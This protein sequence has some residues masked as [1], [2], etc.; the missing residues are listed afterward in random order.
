MVTEFALVFPPAGSPLVRLDFA[1]LSYRQE[2]TPQR[3]AP[4]KVD[5]KG[6][7]IQFLGPLQL[8]ETL[9][10]AADLIG[11]V[12]GITA[13]PAGVTARFSLPIP[14]VRC[15]AFS[16]SNVVFHSAV[17][18]PFG[19]DP[20]AVSIGFASRAN[21]FALSVLV[22]GGGGYVDIRLDANGP[23]IE[24]SLEF[25]AMMSVDF[26][27]ASGEVH[28]LG[29]VRYLQEGSSVE[30][31]G[32]VRIGGSVDVL[33]LVSVSIELVVSLAYDFGRKL[34][35]GRATLVLEIDLTFW[36]DSIEIDSGE[37]VLQGG[38]ET[39]RTI[40]VRDADGRPFGDRILEDDE[41]VFA[42]LDAP[43][44]DE[45]LAAWRDYRSAFAR[46]RGDG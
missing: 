14:A 41:L 15:G 17:E 39:V 22:F 44:T 16:L 45:E 42:G 32:F 12:P 10:K 36:S 26:V 11:S 38:D 19:G 34:L 27:V 5:V 23:R 33:G 8:L 43:P 25:G 35:A 40:R 20:V 4:P 24:A 37:W 6:F 18:V 13:T 9:R 1:E 2:T 3:A 28:A 46:R 31:T 30:L 21:P 7:D 29:G